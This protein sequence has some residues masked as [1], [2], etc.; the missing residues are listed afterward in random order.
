MSNRNFY[1][2]VSVYGS[3]IL[4]RGIEN[5]RRVRNKID[6]HPT[7]YVPSNKPNQHQLS[8]TQYTGVMGEHLSEIK[9]GN[10]RECRDFVKK[11]DDVEGFKIHGNQK[12]EY[13]FIAETY[14]KTIDWDL[15]HINICNIDIEVASE[16]GFPEPDDAKEAITAI[17]MKRM[18]RNKD[19]PFIVFGCGDFVLDKNRSDVRYIKCRD[20][21]DLISRFIVEWES[22]HP[23]IVTGWNVRLFDIPYIVNRITKLLGESM[24][25]RLSPWNVINERQVNIDGRTFKSYNLLGISVLDYIELYKKYAPEGKSQESHKLDNI[26]NVE[27]GERKLSYEEYGNLHTLY[28]DNYQKFIEYNI[29]DVELIEKLE[30]KLKLIELA[31]TLAYDSKTNYDDIFAQVR[32]WDA[33]I[34]NFLRERNIV[35]PPMKGSTNK[36]EYDGGY[37]KDPII[38]RHKW[39]ASFDLNS[40]YPSLIQQY[41]ISPEMFINPVDWTDEMRLLATSGVDVDSML[42]EEIDITQLKSLHAIMTPNGQFFRTDKQGFLSEMME[43]MYVVRNEYK[44]KAI[45]AKKEL[46]LETDPKIRYEI[47]KRAARYNNLQLGKKVC[48]NSAYGALGN[49]FFRFFDVRQAE[50]ITTSGQ[51]SIRWI[52]KKLNQYMNKILRTENDDYTIASDTDSIYLSLSRL[53]HE[54]I[55][56]ENPTATTEEII[57][58][59]D[60]ICEAKI[61]PFI[62]KSFGDLAEYTNAVRQ[63]MQMKREALVDVGI[64]TAKKRY[65]LNIHNNEG[66]QYAQPKLKVSGLEMIK[67]STPSICKVKLKEAVKI[68]F[69]KDENAV[70]DFINDFREEFKKLPVPEIAFPRGVKGLTKYKGTGNSI[71]GEKTPIHVRGSLVYNHLL[72]KHKLTKKYEMIKEGEKIKFVYLKEPNSIQSNIISF[73]N[74]IPSEFELAQYIDYETQYQKSFVEPLKI[75][76]DSIGWKTE[77]VSSLSAFFS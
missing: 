58:F 14:P 67:S 20:E 42:N 52:E 19:R 36:E 5:G 50:A 43:E 32:M 12:Y 23:D 10:I 57:S 24:A 75:I 37:V 29:V 56:K 70:I 21:I 3:R 7:L 74:V 18:G 69:D 65:I 62:D 46:E 39:V 49:Q 71:F 13:A 27:L 60:R 64:W 26:A 25:Q 1:T 77:H 61:G 40:L 55:I 6:Y 33:L 66:V 48:L 17:T 38:G 54:T 30:D 28:R 51:L 35:I 31:L 73:T 44:K 59:M 72:Q 22:D 16:N 11:Y 63:K 45:E 15:E 76:L 2:N 41:N 53:V 4:Y 9:P 68:I 34:Y 8:S 47:E